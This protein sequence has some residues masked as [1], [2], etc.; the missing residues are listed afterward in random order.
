VDIEN[1]KEN[2]AKWGE[3]MPNYPYKLSPGA[4]VKFGANIPFKKGIPKSSL[5]SFEKCDPLDERRR[6]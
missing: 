4:T 1:F 6:M 5:T 3:W 2:Q